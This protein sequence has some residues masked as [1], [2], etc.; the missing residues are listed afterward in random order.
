MK[1]KTSLQAVLFLVL[2]CFAFSESSAQGLRDRARFTT[3]KKYW[4]FGGMITTA[5]FMGD[6]SPSNNKGSIDWS[7][8]KFQFGGFLQ[9]RMTPRVS[10]RVSLNN[11]LFTG[12][13]ADAE[14]NAN[15]GL[16][17]TTY[18]L[19]LNGMAIID[20]FPNAGV[21]YRRPKVPIPYLGLGIG[22]L[23]STANVRQDPEPGYGGDVIEGEQRVTT[24]TYVIPV[25][26]GVRYKLTTHLDIAF[27]ATANYTGSDKIDGIDNSVN[28]SPG[29][30]YN[31]A[32]LTLGFQINYI[33]GGAVKMPK[34][35]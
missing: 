2:M 18:A 17:F 31:D 8:T 13:D 19:Q 9:R 30:Q 12:S 32:F 1:L 34:F 22:A 35:R 24:T 14:R 3:K 6:L 29:Q 33:L 28:S 7:N 21:F 23:F 4:S 25:A 20:L 16:S 15:R 26:L 27:E 11:N 10:A 5:N